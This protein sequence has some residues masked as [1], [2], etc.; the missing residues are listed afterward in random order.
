MSR[1]QVSRIIW[2]AGAATFLSSIVYS[3]YL[4]GGPAVPMPETGQIFPQDL[5]GHVAYITSWQRILLRVTFGISF[6]LGLIFVALGLGD[7]KNK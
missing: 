4:N 3:L 1:E 6:G 5:H 7:T 2:V